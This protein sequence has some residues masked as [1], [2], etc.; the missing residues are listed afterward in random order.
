MIQINKSF[1][2]ISGINDDNILNL[3]VKDQ[4]LSRK[5]SIK[6]PTII[7][8]DWFS[9]FGIIISEDRVVENAVT[10]DDIITY[11][12]YTSFTNI[13]NGVDIKKT[14]AYNF[15]TTLLSSNNILNVDINGDI[16]TVSFLV[17]R[18]M[19][20]RIVCSDISLLQNIIVTGAN[21]TLDTTDKKLYGSLGSFSSTNFRSIDLILSSS[22]FNTVLRKTYLQGK[23]EEVTFNTRNLLSNM[24]LTKNLISKPIITSQLIVESNVGSEVILDTQELGSIIWLPNNPNELYNFD[25]SD[26]YVE[27]GDRE[28]KFLTLSP[29]TKYKKGGIFGFSF[30][31]TTTNPSSYKLKISK[32]NWNKNFLG[33]SVYTYSQLSLGIDGVGFA[34]FDSNRLDFYISLPDSDVRFMD[35]EVY[36]GSKKV[37]ETKTIELYNSCNNFDTIFFLNKIGGIDSFE[38]FSGIERTKE[39][40]DNQTYYGNYK[41][42]RNTA[43]KVSSYST[44]Y[45]TELMNNEECEWLFDLGQSYYTFFTNMTTKT[46]TPFIIT[47]IQDFT[48]STGD[49][50]K[51]F[52]ITIDE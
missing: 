13:N 5:I 2:S 12:P 35:V 50:G 29:K 39:I 46:F 1:S 22:K 48:Y 42:V 32:K 9:S 37:S 36:N 40:S 49:S 41:G 52:K 34:D 11:Y 18:S 51:I 15:Y 30:L 44:T 10:S 4:N 43:Y 21:L 38:R 3:N 45:K 23:D 16:D 31:T 47:K 14:V 20:I 24:N 28:Q 6:F 19:S 17:D 33:S 7:K 26:Y 8:D 25:Y 27:N